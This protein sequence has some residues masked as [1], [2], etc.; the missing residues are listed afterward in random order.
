MN[1][2]LP[3]N[4]FVYGTLLFSEVTDRLAIVSV[5]SS[6]KEIPLRRKAASLRG[7][8]RFTVQPGRR[9]AYPAI[10]Q[11]SGSVEGLVLMDLSARSL[12]ALDEFEGV[13]SGLYSRETVTVRLD[14][15]EEMRV[16]AYV[17]GQSIRKQLSGRWSP[18]TFREEQL[19]WYL[20]YVVGN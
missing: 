1:A 7:F 6:G 9:G 4:V 3:A 11:G 5:D 17:C 20:K 12:H 19:E 13:D 2:V 15:G 8:E 14:S 10:V 18:K 16:F